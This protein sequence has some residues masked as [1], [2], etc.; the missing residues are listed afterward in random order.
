MGHSVCNAL[1]ECLCVWVL[2]IGTRIGT[3][4][5]PLW[6]GTL[7]G[8]ENRV[9]HINNNSPQCSLGTCWRQ[10]RTLHLAGPRQLSLCRAQ[11]RGSHSYSLLWTCPGSQGLLTEQ[12]EA[13]QGVRGFVFSISIW[14]LCWCLC[15]TH[16]ASDI[17]YDF[18]SYPRK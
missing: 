9:L 2:F 8:F 5:Q 4:F 1:G 14:E 18:I 13:R 10:V 15:W 12:F 11:V 16:L 6:R 7:C 3:E 17:Y